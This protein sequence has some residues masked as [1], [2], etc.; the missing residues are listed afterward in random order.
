MAA[1]GCV[2][3][4]GAARGLYWRPARAAAGLQGSRCRRAYAVGPAQPLPRNDLPRIEG[5]LLLGE[6]VRWETSLQLIMDV[7]LSNGSPGTSLAT[8]PYPHLPV[9]AS[10]MDLLWMAEAKMP[11]D[12]PMSDVYGA[13]LFHQYLQKATRD[14]AP[15]LGAGGPRQQRPSASQS[16][17][18]ILVCTGVYNPRGPQSTEPVLG[19]EEPPFHGHRDFCFSSGLMEA[20]H[21]VK[22]VNEAVQLVFRKEGWAWE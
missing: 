22:D 8:V 1:W 14:G 11:R 15:E 18:S 13:N 3:A 20:S 6:P 12:N 10:N 4:L 5:V 7:L 16:C 17:I 2:A 9:L 21:V 19:G